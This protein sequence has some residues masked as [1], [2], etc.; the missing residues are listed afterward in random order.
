MK[1]SD[2]QIGADA[3]PF[4]IAEMSG[5][6]NQSLDRALQIVDEAARAGVAALK[7]QTY[8]ADSL[9]M[10]VNSDEFLITD[11]ESPWSGKSLH[12]LYTL[13][14][15]PLEWH[16]PIFERAHQHGLVC[17][18]TPFDED[19]VDFLESFDVPAYKIASFEIVH[20]PL[21]RRVATTG[22]PIIMSTGMASIREIAEAV[23]AARSSGCQDIVLLKCTSTYPAS[24]R[25]SNIRTLP[26]LQSAFQCQVGISDHTLGVGVAVASVALGAT[27]I[28]KHLTIDREEGGVDSAFSMEPAEMK[29]LVA[30]VNRAWSSL[31]SVAYGPSSGDYKSLKFRRSIYLAK[32]VASGEHLTAEH[33]RIVRPAGGL[34]PSAF[35]LLVGRRVKSAQKR[36]T[37]TSWSLFD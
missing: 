29:L 18:S 5:N 13:A 8:T 37:P 21:I 34:P 28:E 12:E 20:L 30:E 24:P 4:V 16:R 11:K 23:E 33:L 9:T 6:H 26:H 35:D 7:L 19:A 3:P 1:I 14:H 15:T 25:D 2:R 10:D 17:F 31:G 22:K 32:D 36:G 27:V